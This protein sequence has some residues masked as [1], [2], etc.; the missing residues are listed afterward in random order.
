VYGP[1]IR[2]AVLPDADQTGCSASIGFLAATT[3]N[4]T[5]EMVE[6]IT[7]P[8]SV[9]IEMAP[10]TGVNVQCNCSF[11]P[12]DVL[13]PPPISA[14]V[15]LVLN[16]CARYAWTDTTFNICN[17]QE[18]ADTCNTVFPFATTIKP[19]GRYQV[20]G[21]RLNS[22]GRCLVSPVQGTVT[23]PPPPPPRTPRQQCVDQCNVEAADCMADAHTGTERGVCGRANVACKRQ[24]PP[25]PP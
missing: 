21:Y 22:A 4:A 8:D 11:W 2:F 16:G 10:I 6:A 23:D 3:V 19:D 5:H 7:D 25:P 15:G 17:P 18:I 13:L 1:K 20:S 12:I 14:P 24:C 9:I